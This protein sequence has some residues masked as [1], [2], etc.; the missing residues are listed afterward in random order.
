M[1]LGL[2]LA[3]GM[4]Q[5]SPVIPLA[6]SQHR[7]LRA[8]GTLVEKSVDLRCVGL[9]LSSHVDSVVHSLAPCHFVVVLKSGCVAPTSFFLCPE[10]LAVL[11]PVCMNS[12]SILDS[13]RHPCDIRDLQGAEEQNLRDTQSQAVQ[14]AGREGPGPCWAGHAGCHLRVCK[15]ILMVLLW[16]LQIPVSKSWRERP[17]G[18]VPCLSFRSVGRKEAAAFPSNFVPE[19]GAAAGD[20]FHCI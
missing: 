17:V 8:L 11:S 15:Q 12:E 18:R 6:L 1:D 14:G 10:G 3:P 4:R 9:F 19:D 16:S 7:V 2:V 20:R 5:G 13:L